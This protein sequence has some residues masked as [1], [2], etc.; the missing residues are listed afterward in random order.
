[1]TEESKDDI[2]TLIEC[3]GLDVDVHK[4]IKELEKSR[5]E[6]LSRKNFRNEVISHKAL[7]HETRFLIY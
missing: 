7:G 6:I 1:M 3:I 5:D 4:Y 2:K